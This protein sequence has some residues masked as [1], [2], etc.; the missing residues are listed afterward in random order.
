[1]DAASIRVDAP[2]VP[3]Y[4]GKIVRIIGKCELFDSGSS[5]AILHANGKVDLA[6]NNTTFE[7]NKN[8]EIIGKVATDSA[9]VLVLSAVELSDNV[10]LDVAS[11]LVQYVHKVPELYY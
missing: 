9:T 2:L 4:Q 10:N 6:V 1:M 5:R 11:K 7:I 8:Y 3:E